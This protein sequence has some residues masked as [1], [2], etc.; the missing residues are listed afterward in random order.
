MVAIILEK[1]VRI[2]LI[3]LLGLL[4]YRKGLLD[5]PSIGKLSDLLLMIINPMVIFVSYQMDYNP[6][7][8]HNLFLT[9]GISAAAF[10]V[11]ILLVHLLVPQKGNG[12]IERLC[13]VYGNCGFIGIPL[14]NSL[15]GREG[16]FY[17][18]AYLTVFHLFFWTHGVVVMAG[19]T[20]WKSTAQK[21]LSPA[22]IGVMLGLVCFLA[23]IRLPETVVGAMD[24]VGSM[25]T[26]LAMLVAGATLGQSDFRTCFG[27]RR[28][29]WISALKLLLVPLA[30]IVLLLPVK[31]PE[32][33]AAVL[34]IAAACP[35]AASCTMFAL[36]YKRDGFYASRIFAVT[37]VACVLTIPVVVWLAELLGVL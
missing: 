19:K 27:N 32:M 23:R 21:I 12:S 6:Q 10:A 8:L 17:L 24:S 1:I 31:A 35:T 30:T 22:I 4:C 34:L 14:I 28:A 18:T 11:Q 3:L 26:P 25:N 5:D 7:L 37:T 16:V 9:M 15:Y 36:K 13:A 20:D 29:Y 2:F 33:I